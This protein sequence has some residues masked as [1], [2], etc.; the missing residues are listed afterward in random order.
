MARTTSE[1]VAAIIDVD[2]SIDLTPFITTANLLVTTHCAA[3]NSDYTATELEEI[4][5]YLAAHLSTLIDPR[6]TQETAGKVSAWYQS[7]VDLGFATSHY[8]QMAMLLDW[9]GGLAA[10]NER[11]KKGGKKTVGISWLGTESETLDEEE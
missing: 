9:Y 10:L 4:E 6:P 7:K 3:L 8:G 1:A 5:R 2:S 11:M